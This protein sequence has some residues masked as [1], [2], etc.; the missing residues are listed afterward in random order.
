MLFMPERNQIETIR[1]FVEKREEDIFKI[2]YTSQI[3][4]VNKVIEWLKQEGDH[5][6]LEWISQV[7]HRR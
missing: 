5:Q 1:L 7:T 2:I 4:L 6:S 3:D